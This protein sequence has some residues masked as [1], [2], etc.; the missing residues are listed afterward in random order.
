L[1]SRCIFRSW[2]ARSTDPGE[3]HDSQLGVTFGRGVGMIFKDGVPMRKVA[4]E[5]IVDAFVM[6]T[7]KLL[8]EGKAAQSEVRH[9]LVSIS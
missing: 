4:G 3:A 9:E 6:E 1:K 2:V 5:N 8:A 7:E